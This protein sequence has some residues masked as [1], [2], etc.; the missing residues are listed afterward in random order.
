MPWQQPSHQR[1]AWVLRVAFGNWFW[2]PKLKDGDAAKCGIG[3]VISLQTAMIA[4]VIALIG[5]VYAK[6]DSPPQWRVAISY[7][8]LSVL[9]LIGMFLIYVLRSNTTKN[10]PAFDRSTIMFTRCSLIVSLM[11]IAIV[12]AAYRWQLLPGQNVRR[13]PLDVFHAEQSTFRGSREAPDDVLNREIK[14][15]DGKI[16]ISVSLCPWKFARTS[17][18]E[19]VQIEVFLAP[20][21]AASWRFVDVTGK[22]LDGR[23]CQRQPIMSGSEPYKKRIDWS[24]LDVKRGYVMNLILHQTAESPRSPREQRVTRKIVMHPEAAITATA[25][26]PM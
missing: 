3:A 11:V 2:K 4:E 19:I 18:P 7:L 15:H 1:T 8:A 14:Q 21:V 20:D 24:E 9:P 22:E 16:V 17:V 12:T 6:Q 10:A 13:I 23:I 5:Y 25:F 26:Y